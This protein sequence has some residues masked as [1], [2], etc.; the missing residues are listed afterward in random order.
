MSSIKLAAAIVV[1]AALGIGYAPV[2]IFIA[3]QIGALAR[4]VAGVP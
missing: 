3:A 4:A 1:S 2:V